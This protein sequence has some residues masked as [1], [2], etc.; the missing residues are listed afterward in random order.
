MNL[1]KQESTVLMLCITLHVCAY[2]LCKVYAC[3]DLAGTCTYIY[4]VMFTSG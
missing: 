4:I 2:I 1:D 3:Y